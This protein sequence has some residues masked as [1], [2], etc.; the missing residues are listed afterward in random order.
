MSEFAPFASTSA[1]S[2]TASSE[3]REERQL[4]NRISRLWR[5]PVPRG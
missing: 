3:E 2:T 1:R 5:Q 4:F